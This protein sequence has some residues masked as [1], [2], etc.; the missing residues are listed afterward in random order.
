MDLSPRHHR[1][2]HCGADSDTLLH[3]LTCDGRQGAVEEV[4]DA[5]ARATDPEPSH[6]AAAV[7]DAAGLEHQVRAALADGPLTTEQLADRIGVPR[8]SISPRM[9]SLERKQQV[10]R[11]GKRAN[12]SGVRAITWGLVE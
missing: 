12:R 10:E 5:F 1:C 2:A 4:A 11:V 3:I 7:V 6:V 8:D 9:R